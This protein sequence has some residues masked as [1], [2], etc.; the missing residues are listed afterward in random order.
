MLTVALAVLTGLVALADWTAV[1][2][3]RKDLETWLK[4]A[5]LVLLILTVVAAGALG[6]TAGVWLAVAL[7]LGLVGDV[8]LLDDTVESRFITGLAA[9][10]VGHLAYV[11]CFVILGLTMGWWL[12]GGIAVMVVALAVGNGVLPGAMREDGWALV[13]PIAV[14]MAVIAAMTITAW[15]TQE[16]WIAVGASIFVVSDSSLAIN[17]FVKPFRGARPLIMTTYHVGQ[18]LIAVGVL[19]LLGS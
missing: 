13:V 9:F 3:E 6:H 16:W 7:V 2:R 14:Y 8:A 18:A 1:V 19:V 4:P 15:L 17:K 10:L 5:V 12:A 11:V